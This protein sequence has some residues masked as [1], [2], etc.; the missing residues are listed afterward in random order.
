MALEREGVLSAEQSEVVGARLRSAS[1]SEEGRSGRVVSA[2]GGIGALLLGAGVLYLVAYNW[3]QLARASKL[4]LIFATWLGLH[5]A[6]YRLGRDPGHYPRL[7]MALSAAGVLAFG[8]AIALLAQI[9]NLSAKYPWS[10]LL[11]WT[12]NLPLVLVSGSLLLLLVVTGLFVV[13]SFWHAGVYLDSLDTLWSHSE[14]LAAPRTASKLFCR[15][16]LMV[17]PP[18]SW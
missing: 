4:A 16:R 2:I 7:G 18:R 11:W 9:Y 10:V 6:G 8:G 17:N 13:W 5:T 12:L 1:E 3:D 14:L 15:H